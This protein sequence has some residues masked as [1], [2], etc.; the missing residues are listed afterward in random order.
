MVNKNNRPR[1]HIW[2]KI[3]ILIIGLSLIALAGS[4]I[5]AAP[6]F[7]FGNKVNCPVIRDRLNLTTE[8][9]TKLNELQEKHWKDTIFLRKE[10][11]DQA[12]GPKHSLERAKSR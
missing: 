8:Q 11:S 3:K 4:V 2:E 9:K 1:R 7:G 12:F 10:M 5:A 6:G